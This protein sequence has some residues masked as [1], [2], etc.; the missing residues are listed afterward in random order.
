MHNVYN[1]Y[2]VVYRKSYDNAGCS[3]ALKKWFPFEI[4]NS[5]IPGKLNKLNIRAH[6]KKKKQI[7]MVVVEVVVVVVMMVVVVIM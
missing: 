1:S 3:V 7:R 4:T 5:K 2:D 6:I